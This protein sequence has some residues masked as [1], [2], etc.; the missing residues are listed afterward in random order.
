MTQATYRL[1]GSIGRTTLGLI[2]LQVDET[3]EHDFRRLFPAPEVA[4]HVSRV[5][6]GADLTPETIAGMEAHLTQAAALLPPAARFDA[7]GYACTSA[8]TLI[9]AERVAGLLRGGAQAG[10]VTDPLSAALAA[11][12]ALSVRRIALVSPYIAEV[13]GPVRDAFEAAGVAV[14]Q[15]LSFGER[16]EARVARIDP[17][18]TRA[19]A[20][21]IG[22]RPGVEAVFLSCTNLRTLDIIAGLEAE[23]GLPVVSSNLALAWHMARLSG[24]PLSGAVPARLCAG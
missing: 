5:A 14:P 19:A 24:A 11:M 12:A 1:T 17:A 4:L 7:L 15:M 6:S 23:L 10:A 16:V 9:G 22:R 21:E 18:S 8:A 3:V 2:V 20:L 13:G